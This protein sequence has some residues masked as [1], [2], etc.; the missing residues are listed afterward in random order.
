MSTEIE[1]ASEED[2]SEEDTDAAEE[3]S[4]RRSHRRKAERNADGVTYAQW[5]ERADLTGQSKPV[6]FKAWRECVKPET[7]AADNPKSGMS[8]GAKIALGAVGL[9][10]VGGL[11]AGGVWAYRRYFAGGSGSNAAKKW[12]RSPNGII[13]PNTPARIAISAAAIQSLLPGFDSTALVAN[14]QSFNF[15]NISAW[16]PG[17][18]P[19]WAYSDDPNPTSEFHAQFTNGNQVVDMTKI[20]PGVWTVWVYG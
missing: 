12:Q 18:N 20:P 3:R 7:Y 16:A 6:Y 15:N 13:P 5:L 19:G 11:V 14:F 8:T 4:R 10:A 1:R 2:A 17:Q 9:V